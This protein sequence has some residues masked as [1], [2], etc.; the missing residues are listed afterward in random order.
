MILTGQE[1][2]DFLKAAVNLIDAD[3]Q[4]MTLAGKSIALL[5]RVNRPDNTVVVQGVTPDQ[6]KQA[7]DRFG[8]AGDPN[9]SLSIGVSAT[10]NGK[11]E[12][13]NLFLDK[14]ADGDVMLTMARAQMKN[15]P[16]QAD[17][18]E[19]LR[20]GIMPGLQ[21]VSQMVEYV[22]PVTATRHQM[23][24]AVKRVVTDKSPYR[25]FSGRNFSYT[26]YSR[27]S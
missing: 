8:A 20:T 1:A 12:S 10:F 15:A 18:A 16:T 22:G 14:T 13:I 4:T 3:V 23:T 5:T 2:R 21:Q 7:I 17:I 9:E 25:A 24:E 27:P 19:A 11:P 26:P 6:F